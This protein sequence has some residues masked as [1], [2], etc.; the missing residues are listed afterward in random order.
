MILNFLLFFLAIDPVQKSTYSPYWNKPETTSE[1][2]YPAAGNQLNNEVD[3]PN[4]LGLTKPRNGN[5]R[6][7][8][9][10][11]LVVFEI[12]AIYLYTI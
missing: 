11:F 4:Q 9:V 3:E 6:N 7:I 10:L 8:S 5:V 12:I 2:W 1:T